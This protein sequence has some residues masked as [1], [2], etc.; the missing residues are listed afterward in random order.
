MKENLADE[1]SISNSE[2]SSGPCSCTSCENYSSLTCCNATEISSDDKNVRSELL[3]T[4]FPKILSVYA[5]FQAGFNAIYMIDGEISFKTSRKNTSEG[6][7]ASLMKQKNSKELE[8]Y[9]GKVT[10]E[11]N[12]ALSAMTTLRRNKV[13]HQLNNSFGNLETMHPVEL[14]KQIEIVLREALDSD[15]ETMSKLNLGQVYV[16]MMDEGLITQRENPDSDAF[17]SIDLFIFKPKAPTEKEITEAQG[18]VE[19]QFEYLDNVG[20]DKS[21]GESWNSKKSESG[22]DLIEEIAVKKTAIRTA[23]NEKNIQKITWKE[24]A[25]SRVTSNLEK[26][27]VKTTFIQN[28][29]TIQ[30][31]VNPKPTEVHQD[32]HQSLGSSTSCDLSC[33]NTNP[34]YRPENDSSYHLTS[35]AT[36]W[37]FEKPRPVK[38]QRSHQEKCS[39]EC[40]KSDSNST[41]DTSDQQSFYE[42]LTFETS[43]VEMDL[44]H[45]EDVQVAITPDRVQNVV[46]SFKIKVLIF[47]LKNL[48]L[49]L[50]YFCL[51]EFDS[52][53]AKSRND[54]STSIDADLIY[55]SEP[56]VAH[57]SYKKPQI[58][59]FED[60]GIGSPL[61]DDFAKQVH[62][63][64][65]ESQSSLLKGI[66]LDSTQGLGNE[67]LNLNEKQDGKRETMI[68]ELKTK[69]VEKFHVLS[70]GSSSADTETLQS[71]HLQIPLAKQ[72][73]VTRLC[74][75]FENSRGKL[76]KK[77]D[78]ETVEDR[79]LK[80]TSRSQVLDLP[81]A[82]NVNPKIGIV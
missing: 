59:D 25:G 72:V 43:S 75:V 60:S 27:T 4:K 73:V 35:G 44:E 58:S 46:E 7:T 10:I 33:C 71:N 55:N 53:S 2:S 61:C 54:K 13:L 42:M 63:V 16:P 65:K 48:K 80:E 26:E 50:Q 57:G 31:E 29:S 51:Q 78:L 64:H 12:D 23:K 24:L 32:D 3:N 49:Q 36:S 68:R 6:K 74:K 70:S 15:F 38:C 14:G 37:D 56:K 22:V 11:W 62:R 82:T 28:G 20:L 76:A 5:K 52:L 47:N 77:A 34:N 39:T 17:T 41:F 69:L 30:T 18:E 9:L 81:I 45:Q 67:P 8:K 19:Q 40:C 1:V 79:D 66:L 21:L